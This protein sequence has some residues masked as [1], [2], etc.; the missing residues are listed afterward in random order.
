MLGYA[1]HLICP[2][3]KTKINVNFANL[4]F[5]CLLTA[6]KHLQSVPRSRVPYYFIYQIIVIKF[7]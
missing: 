2:N 1:K 5:F 4:Y 3:F 7:D 6:L